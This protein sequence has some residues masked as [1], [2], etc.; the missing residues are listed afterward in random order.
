VSDEKVVIHVDD[1]DAVGYGKPPK[2]TRFKKGKSGN[3]KGRPKRKPEVVD[4]EHLFIEELF[5]KVTATING[6]TQKVPAWKLIAK[7]LVARS[8]KGDMRAIRTYKDFSDNFKLISEKQ[9]IQKADDDRRLIEMVR[10]EL[11]RWDAG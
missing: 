7:Q 8:I 9:K 2:H 10:N 11:D 6:R 3:P 5:Q 4:I 1:D